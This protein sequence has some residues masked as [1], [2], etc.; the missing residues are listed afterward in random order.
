M[1][2]TRLRTGSLGAMLAVASALLIAPAA[3]AAE[4]TA[5]A[6]AQD[7]AYQVQTHETLC[8]PKG[9]DLEAAWQAK[10]GRT[11]VDGPAEASRTPSDRV[12]G[13]RTPLAAADYRMATVYDNINYG[14]SSLS[15]YNNNPC[16]PGGEIYFNYPSSWFGR[17][18]S[19][20]GSSSCRI[21]I[22]QFRD[23]LGPSDGYKYSIPFPSDSFLNDNTRSISVTY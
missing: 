21:K 23:M 11:V 9:G 20:K 22:W 5:G 14:G 10:T 2:S 1:F 8:V 18:S 12:G 7:C 15:F 6:E 17:V 16:T 4:P 3:Q 13:R 19:A